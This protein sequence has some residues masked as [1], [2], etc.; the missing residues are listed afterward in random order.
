MRQAFRPASRTCFAVVSR[1]VEATKATSAPA[2][3]NPIAIALPRP[4]LAPVTTAT[5]PSSLNLSRI[6][7]L[8]QC[9]DGRGIHI[10]EGLILS[11]HAPAKRVS[12]G[13]ATAMNG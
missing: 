10:L 5:F 7:Q 2:S 13:A 3:A 4:L 11:A 9:L 6:I 12:A 1:L 8:P